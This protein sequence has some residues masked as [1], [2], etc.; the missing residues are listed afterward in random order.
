MT[1]CNRHGVYFGLEFT[2]GGLVDA[3]VPHLLVAIQLLPRPEDTSQGVWDNSV[4]AE[5][6]GMWEDRVV[7][8]KHQLRRDSTPHEQ[9]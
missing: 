9:R 1:S 7:W 6:L 8:L 4:H 3:G 2:P 5:K